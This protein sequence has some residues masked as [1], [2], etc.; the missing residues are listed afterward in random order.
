MPV[1]E[2]L[3]KSRMPAELREAVTGGQASGVLTSIVAVGIWS[4]RPEAT[5]HW[6]RTMRALHEA[7]LLDDRL[8]ELVRLRIAAH[9][10]CRSCQVARKSD[11]VT[12]EDAACIAVD[13]ARWTPVEQAALTFADLF[14]S[15]HTAIEETHFREL[16]RHFSVDEIVELGLFCGLMLAGGRLNYVMR[17]WADDDQPTL[18][19]LE[20]EPA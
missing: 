19:P 11:R 12:D 15:D 2:P 5:L 3:P 1:I 6:V 17:G 18:F 9:T 14:A 20:P 8:R 10:D 13:D 7:S 16:A 4:R